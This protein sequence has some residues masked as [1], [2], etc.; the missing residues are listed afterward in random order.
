MEYKYTGII[1]NKKDIGETD[2]IYNIYTLE[3]GKIS[4]I[5]RG[6]RKSQSKLAGH[7]ENYYLV[8]LT[9]M[10]NRGMGNISS[11]IVE[12]N[13]KNIR[14]N[15]DSLEKVFK[16]TKSL[17]RLIN[18]Q[19]KDTDV[20]FLFLDFLVSLDKISNDADEV[21]KNLMTQCFV[22]KLLDALG[23]KIEISRCVKCEGTL[24]KNRNFFDYDR[25]GMICEHCAA[26]SDSILPISNN[27]IKI[28]RI[29]FQNKISNLAKLRINQRE[30][31]ELSQ[32]SQTF[33]KWIC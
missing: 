1:L 6:V 12:N 2:R 33:I 4:A 25:G 11:S 20:F 8:D 7:L 10:R 18:D 13:F 9:V 26:T 5:A 29:F 19:E 17:N 14:N 32:I 15:L 28:I 21:K 16:T 22:F 23:Y 24:S 31:K 3:Q 30:S 27:S